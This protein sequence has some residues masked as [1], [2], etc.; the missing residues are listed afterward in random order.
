ME[1]AA[2]FSRH[3]SWDDPWVLSALRE[4]ETA[5]A[6]IDEPNIGGLHGTDHVT[7]PLAY[8]RLHG[9]NSKKWFHSQNRDERYDYLYKPAELEPIAK[10]LKAM[11]KKVE[12][13]PSRRQI[14]KV[15]AA[16][17]NHYKG[18]AAVNA[19]DLKRLLGIKNNPVRD[20]LAKAC[21]Q[22]KRAAR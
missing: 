19:I 11:A 13:E 4:H 1:F 5:W 8:L 20:Q 18:Q 3:E 22:L 7:A 6:N 15:V 9:R 12:K 2:I 16:T 21:P 17:N 10:S 14:K